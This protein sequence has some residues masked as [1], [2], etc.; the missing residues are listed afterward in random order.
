MKLGLIGWYGHSNY[1]DERILYCIK[2]FFLDHD[3]FITSGWDDA[4]LK[5]NELNKCDYILIGG[6]GLILRNIGY[7]TD[8]MRELRRPFGFIGVSIEAKHR[9]ME[10]FFE[11][12]KQK[13]EFI[14]VRDM[15]SR[16]YLDNHYKVIVGPDLTFLYPFDV[17]S[18]VKDDVC[19]FNLRD[20][21][22]WKCVLHGHY[23]NII[24]R[25]DRRFPWLEKIYPFEKWDPN[26][27]VEIVK[28]MFKEILPIPFYFESNAL[29][30]LNVLSKYFKKVPSPFNINIYNNIRYLVGM[31]YH[32]IV[33]AT[34]CGIPFISLS[35]QPKNINFCSEIGLDILSADIY[36][37]NE[38]NRKIDYIKNN[39][40][41]IREHLINY[42]EKCTK[43]INY[44]FQS[45]SNLILSE[46]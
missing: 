40:L 11:I 28:R 6:G 33:F 26:I 29:N 8:I 17:V 35:Y 20:W 43:D 4:R 7:Q 31:R 37:I 27:V 32:S 16:E 38:L 45:I 41:K 9:S 15:K 36:K 22:Y 42:R 44:I 18:E 1:G 13:S 5:I 2:R 14:L 21:Y 3:F 25:L 46:D 10:N 23:Y 34:Q 12:M 19:G 30:D 39:Y 24:R